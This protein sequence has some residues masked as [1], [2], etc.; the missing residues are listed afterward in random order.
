[1]IFGYAPMT[2]SGSCIRGKTS[3]NEKHLKEEREKLGFYK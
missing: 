3:I 1:M 2:A